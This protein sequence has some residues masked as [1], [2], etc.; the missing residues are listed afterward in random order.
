MREKKTMLLDA[1][2]T[3]AHNSL[4]SAQSDQGL[5]YSLQLSER[6]AASHYF[7]YM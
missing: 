6:D 3:K 2:K 1:K 4:A 7:N 5:R